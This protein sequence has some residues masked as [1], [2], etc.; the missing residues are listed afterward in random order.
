[1][2]MQ[3]DWYVCKKID[4]NTYS[5]VHELPSIITMQNFEGEYYSYT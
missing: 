4:T 1:M 3:I 5:N 2:H